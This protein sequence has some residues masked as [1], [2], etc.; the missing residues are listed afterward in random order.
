MKITT[1]LDPA[2]KPVAGAIRRRWR[3][4]SGGNSG[5]RMAVVEA[6]RWRHARRHQRHF[7]SGKRGG[8]VTTVSAVARRKR[9]G[10]G[11]GQRVGSA[12]AARW[13]QA[14]LWQPQPPRQQRWLGHRQKS[15]LNKNQAA[16]QWRWQLGCGGG[17]AVVL[18]AR[19]RRRRYLHIR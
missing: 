5:G 18:A 9:G 19:R 13:Q 15:T 8:S 16:P 10:G 6:A 11:G 12:M 3:Q 17:S 4:R 2:K 14:W 1:S 7:Q